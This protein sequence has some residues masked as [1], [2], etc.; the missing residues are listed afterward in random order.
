MSHVDSFF[1]T[2]TAD[3][4]KSEKFPKGIPENVPGGNKK[5]LSSVSK[6]GATKE[7]QRRE[8]SLL[9]LLLLFSAG[10]SH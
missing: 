6:D 8:A 9:E 3:L 5:N 4:L 10:V 7:A 2:R 1:R